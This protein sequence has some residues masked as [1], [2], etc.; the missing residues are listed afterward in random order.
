M[1]DRVRGEL[2]R[3][4]EVD[5]AA[6]GLGEVEQPPQECLREQAF[7]RVPLVG[8]GNELG[9]VVALAELRDEVVVEDLCT[10]A[11]ERHLRRT[12]ADPHPTSSRGTRACC[13]VPPRPP[14]DTL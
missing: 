3:D 6:V 7:S 2:R 5:R 8:N 9:L 1:A 13:R 12:D 14:T 10:A 11:C 4:D